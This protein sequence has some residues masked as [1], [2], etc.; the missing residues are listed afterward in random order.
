MKYNDL[1]PDYFRKTY[2]RRRI[3]KNDNGNDNIQ[4]YSPYQR[5]FIC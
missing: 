1:G 5:R 3:Y 4:K 2:N